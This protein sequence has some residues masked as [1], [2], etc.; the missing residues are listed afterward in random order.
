MRGRWSPAVE[1]STEEKRVLARCK[2]AKLFVFLRETRHELFDEDR[3]SAVQRFARTMESMRI[4]CSYLGA[5]EIDAARTAG[6][7]HCKAFS[8]RSLACST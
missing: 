1:P 6:T 8:L 3:V 4:D 7:A 5:P 2:K